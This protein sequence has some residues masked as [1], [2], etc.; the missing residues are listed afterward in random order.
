MSKDGFEDNVVIR[1]NNQSSLIEMLEIGNKRTGDADE[2]R[3]ELALQRVSS[4]DGRDCW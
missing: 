2:L 1:L 3:I 4:G